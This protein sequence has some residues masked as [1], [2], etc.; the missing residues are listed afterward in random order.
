MDPDPSAILAALAVHR[1]PSVRW[2]DEMSEAIA[3]PKV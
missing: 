1:N 3:P 2:D